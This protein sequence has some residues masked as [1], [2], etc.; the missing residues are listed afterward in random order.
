MEDVAKGGRTIL[1]VS[2]NMA[3]VNNLCSACI[4][5]QAGKLSNLGPTEETINIYRSL[6]SRPVDK[7][8]GLEIFRPNWAIPL[9]TCVKLK[10]NNDRIGNLI[11]MGEDFSIEITFDTQKFRPLKNPVMGVVIKHA[12]LGTIGGVNTRM[13]GFHPR[14]GPYDTGLMQCTLRHPPLLQGLYLIDV[15][16]GDGLEDLDTLTECIS[17]SI[18]ES[19]IYK[20]GQ[21]PFAQMGTIYLEPEWEICSPS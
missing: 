12:F 7:S 10:I 16:L 4:L 15:W 1:F 2:H 21:T 8:E 20:T 14:T 17:F 6:V 13:T 19:N 3:A 18:A 11:P 5:L 9:I